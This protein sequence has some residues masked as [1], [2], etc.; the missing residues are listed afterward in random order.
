M[1]RQLAVAKARQAPEERRA[2]VAAGWATRWW[3]LLSIAGRNALT[4]TLVDDA[5]DFL[6]GVD[7]A[8]P[9][10]RE[11]LRDGNPGTIL[12]ELHGELETEELPGPGDTGA[13]I[14]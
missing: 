4:G 10:W 9:L 5:P 13:S 2:R 11:V 6:D 7:G 8:E 14:N 3:G 1:L 12:G